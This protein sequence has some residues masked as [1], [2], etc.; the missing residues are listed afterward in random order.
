M[1]THVHASPNVCVYL[2]KKRGVKK[3][4]WLHRAEQ[5]HPPNSWF[6]L[7]V[8]TTLLHRTHCISWVGAECLMTDTYQVK[9]TCIHKE[10]RRQQ[11]SAQLRRPEQ[12]QNTELI[13]GKIMGR[14]EHRSHKVLAADECK[15]L[16]L[17]DNRGITP[18]LRIFSGT[19][20]QD[21]KVLQ[22][23]SRANS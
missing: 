23:F 19:K 2:K 18:H 5:L 3:K 16:C 14:E 17:M 1:C 15:Q 7:I 13:K 8:L 9:Q 21:N 10:G 20:K 22:H 6:L 12:N 11:C 4:Q